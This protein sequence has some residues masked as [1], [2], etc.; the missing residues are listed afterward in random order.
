MNSF[1]VIPMIS[2]KYIPF[3]IS[4]IVTCFCFQ[5]MCRAAETVNYGYDDLDRLVS[6][7][8]VGAG[9]IHYV[10][11]QAGD[12]INITIIRT[13]PAVVDSDS[14]GIADNWEMMFFDD[15]SIASPTSDSDGDRYSDLWE[16]LNWKDGLLDRRGNT[17]DPNTSNASDARGYGVG[18]ERGEFLTAPWIPLL[19]LED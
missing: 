8:Y 2:K 18:L 12:I 6:V 16:Y 9:S 10:Y 11:D 1:K 7:E 13:N 17:F 15:L 4:T 14:D 3:L 5:F 19:L